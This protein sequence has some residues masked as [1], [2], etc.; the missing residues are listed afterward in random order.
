MQFGA[1][2]TSGGGEIENHDEFVMNLKPY[3]VEGTGLEV[4]DEFV[5]VLDPSHPEIREERVK[6]GVEKT[7]N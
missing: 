7:K 1:L 4:H 6:M 5:M 2:E 3:D